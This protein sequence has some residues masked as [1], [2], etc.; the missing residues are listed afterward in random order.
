MQILMSARRD[1][2][3]SARAAVVKTHGEAMSVVVVVTICYT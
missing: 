2:S 1:F 3:A